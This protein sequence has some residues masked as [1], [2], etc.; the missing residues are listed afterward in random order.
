MN[1][2]NRMQSTKTEYYQ[3][4]W[5]IKKE[6]KKEKSKTIQNIVAI[7]KIISI[8]FRLFCFHI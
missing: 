8:D 1:S 3:E 4:I 7:F 5:N 6:K 2:K